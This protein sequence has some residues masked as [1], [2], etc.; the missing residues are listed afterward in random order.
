MKDRQTGLT[1]CL[2][3][4]GDGHPDSLSEWKT[5]EYPAKERKVKII[6]IVFNKVGLNS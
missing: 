6:Y 1:E 4:W 3:K 5:D 2:W